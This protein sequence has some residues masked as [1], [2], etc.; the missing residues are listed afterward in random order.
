MNRTYVQI[1][2]G[3]YH[4]GPRGR[5]PD[6][7]AG[8][9]GD[10]L[11]RLGA[12]QSTT[13]ATLEA[14]MWPRSSCTRTSMGR[15]RSGR[16]RSTAA[17]PRPTS[18]AATISSAVTD[19]GSGVSRCAST[20]T[21]RGVRRLGHVLREPRVTLP[22]VTGPRPSTSSTATLAGNVL[23]LSDTIVLDTTAP[24]GTLSI[25]NGA[26]NTTSVVVT[27]NSSVSD[28]P[29]GLY[30][31]RFSNDN[32]NWSTWEAYAATKNNWSL[33]LGDGTKTVYAQYRDNAGNVS[34]SFSDGIALDG[35]APTGS[36]SINGGAATASTTSV[37]LDLSATDTGGSALHQMRFSNDNTSWSTWE[38]YTATK[39]WTL[40]TGDG[41]KTVYA[42][43]RDNAGNVSATYSDGI[44]LAAAGGTIAT[45]SLSIDTYTYVD[46]NEGA[47]G[48]W[49]PAY[50]IYVNDALIG[51]KI[52]G[53]A[54]TWDCPQIDLPAGGHIDIVTDCGFDYYDFLWAEG[55]P[56]TYTITLP[57]GTTRLEAATWTGFL[58]ERVTTE[59]WDPY[60][61][62]CTWV[63][64][65]PTT[66]GNIVYKTN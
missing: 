33:A 13:S 47:S 42:Q 28:S 64:V 53:G 41:A 57:A 23:T 16:C 26:P 59:Y 65:L 52:A 18:T 19:A 4:C 35:T 43:Y 48:A 56:N 11:A 8:E 51:T 1:D 37:T 49:G 54:T 38:T 29:S 32:T 61:E 22:P 34:G 25:N 7:R 2:G 46:A 62:M 63:D 17:P 12:T 14:L 66:I 60:E 30:Q 5:R 24:V 58:D 10:R 39:S 50:T 45:T 27:L 31:M 40:S 36:I 6:N 15:L 21:A 44:T 3:A 55:R 9:W 20:R